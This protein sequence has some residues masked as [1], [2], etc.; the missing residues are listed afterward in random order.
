MISPKSLLQFTR[1][2]LTPDSNRNKEALGELWKNKNCRT[3]L[4]HSKGE[5]I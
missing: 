1:S 4:D 2:I 3:L 5:F